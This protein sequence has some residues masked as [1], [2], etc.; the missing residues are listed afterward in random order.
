MA[1]RKKKVPCRLPNLGNGRDLV[2][3][4][5]LLS[6]PAEAVD[7]FEGRAAALFWWCRLYLVGGLQGSYRIDAR[8]SASFIHRLGDRHSNF[9][10]GHGIGLESSCA[11]VAS[12]FFWQ[13]HPL[14]KKR[15]LQNGAMMNWFVLALGQWA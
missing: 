5:P 8:Q 7:C 1:G 9:F 10:F 11:S 2:D 4:Q 6:L 14:G 12:P 3:N 13:R 15:A